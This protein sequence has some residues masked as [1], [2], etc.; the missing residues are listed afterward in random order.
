MLTKVTVKEKS[1][2]LWKPAHDTSET[3]W[4][5]PGDYYCVRGSIKKEYKETFKQRLA[6]LACND[7]NG[8]FCW[9]MP[10]ERWVKDV[11][12]GR[13]YS[14]P[15]EIEDTDENRKE[16]CKALNISRELVDE[17]RSWQRLLLFEHEFEK[18]A[19]TDFRRAAIVRVGGGKTLFGL[20]LAS[21]YSNPC[22]L[23]PAYVHRSWIDEAAKWNLPCPAVSTY[24]SAHKIK[25]CDCLILDEALLVANPMTVVHGN[26]LALSRNARCVV[27]LTGTPQ[28]TSP[29]DLR[30]LRA[31]YP[32]S[33]PAEEKPWRFL[34]GKD[35]E[36][37]EVKPGTQAYVTKE[38]DHDTVS[39]FISPYVH[40]VRPEEIIRE[41]PELT[42]QRVYVPRPDQYKLILK[43]A[44]TERGKSKALAQARMC[45][46]GK[47]TDDAG[48]IL[49]E[50]NTAKCDAIVQY[51][52]GV[53]EPAVV[54]AR[55]D[56]MVNDLAN[57]LQRF[58]VRNA[59]ADGPPVPV[60]VLRGG[61]DYNT[62]IERFRSGVSKYLVAN[63]GISQGMNLQE[64]ASIVIFAS[65][66]TKPTD[67]EQ[68]I[69]RVWRPG[70]KK[71]VVVVDVIAEDTLDLPTVELLDRH[72]DRNEA[73]IES[74]LAEEFRKQVGRVG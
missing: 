69:G 36:L 39:K 61:A 70:Q 26:A 1:Y 73:F 71:G 8:K 24:Q 17:L 30:W 55:W 33:V 15:Y 22:V 12:D 42:Y 2:S 47:L 34:F 25:Q 28:S 53:N 51:L 23:A 56:Y 43:G 19:G 45:T 60:S 57:V 72:K 32:G 20:L 11:Y 27:G 9:L 13:I 44:A 62:E 14:K 48:R 18:E 67:R 50:L 59:V 35:T 4:V 29:M 74:A 6:P 3:A 16:L 5:E 58:N 31:V 65:W 46:D 49:A 40:V 38:W 7:S 21:R 63:S 52:A 37:V 64:R 54:F 68:A 10:Y 66:S 41:L